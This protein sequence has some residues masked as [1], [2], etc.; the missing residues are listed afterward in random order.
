NLLPAPPLTPPAIPLSTLP[1]R[2][3]LPKLVGALAWYAEIASAAHPSAVLYNQQSRMPVLTF[4][5]LPNGD[6]VLRVRGISWQGLQGYDATVPFSV[7]AHPLAPSVLN[8]AR[9]SVVPTQQLKIIWTKPEPAEAMR[10]QMADT[11]DFSTILLDQIA[12]SSPFTPTTDLLAGKIYVRVASIA[13]GAQGPWGEVISWQAQP[14]LAPVDL[15]Q[16][17]LRIDSAWVFIDLP[18]P[19]ASERYLARWFACDDNALHPEPWIPNLNGLFQWP[20]PKSGNYCLQV[21]R[22]RSQDGQQSPVSERTI[23]VL[24][25]PQ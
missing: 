23:T 4:A 17:P 25:A 5:D 10:I 9:N 1:I 21:K 11:A 3:N 13:Q 12:Q 8:P 19:K 16:A 7:R 20:R 24:P 6:Y 22:E 2:F 14:A 18:A 15:S